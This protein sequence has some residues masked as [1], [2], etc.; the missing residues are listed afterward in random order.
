MNSSYRY[1]RPDL[2]HERSNDSIHFVLRNQIATNQTLHQAIFPEVSVATSQ[3]IISKMIK[4]G[5]LKRWFYYGTKSLVR[6]GPTAIARW[7]YPPVL[8]R[9]PGPQVLP[10]LWGCL[11]LCTK[12]KPPLLRLLPEELEARFPGFPT[13]RDLQQ[14]AFYCDASDET[15]KLGMIRVEFRTSGAIVIA[16]LCEQLHRYRTHE[17]IN[18]L[19]RSKRIFIHIVT[20]TPEQE[21][22]LWEEAQ[23]QG[24]GVELRTCHDP[25]LTMFL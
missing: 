16:K 10:Y 2:A 7:G 3:K 9:R 15:S 22:S 17:A 11:S 13:S 25:S 24:L 6:L 23:R 5:L 8:A 19:F 21:S 4:R 14:W 18:E 20:A 1:K 12:S